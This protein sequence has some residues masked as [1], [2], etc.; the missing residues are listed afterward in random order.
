MDAVQWTRSTK[1]GSV[2]GGYGGV[3]DPLE[4]RAEFISKTHRYEREVINISGR[5]QD[6]T[7]YLEHNR[8]KYVEIKEQYKDQ[9]VI[10]VCCTTGE[11]QFFQNIA[12]AAVNCNISA[13]GLRN[14]ILTK[15]H[16]NDHHWIFNRDTTHYT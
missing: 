10:K 4:P 3:N 14:R 11:K 6:N 1:F 5:Q 15:V 8:K 12:A 2:Y 13:P 16:V 9:P 7:D